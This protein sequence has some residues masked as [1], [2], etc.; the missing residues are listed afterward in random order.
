MDLEKIQSAIILALSLLRNEVDCIEYDQLQ[1]EYR[2]T[3][4]KLE[5]ALDEISRE[6]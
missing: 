6:E 5:A 3:I 1:K 2:A 4:K